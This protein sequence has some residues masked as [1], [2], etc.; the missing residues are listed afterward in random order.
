MLA[1]ASEGPRLMRVLPLE[2]RSMFC[3]SCCRAHIEPF[4]AGGAAAKAAPQPPSACRDN[5]ASCPQ[6]AKMGECDKNPVYMQGDQNV[7]GHCRLSCKVSLG[8]PV[9]GGVGSARSP[10]TAAACS[11][12]AHAQSR[13]TCCFDPP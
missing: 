11:Q 1:A 9:L 4:L 3:L 6:W 13:R 10:L 8:G 7:R 12:E 2:V 5:H